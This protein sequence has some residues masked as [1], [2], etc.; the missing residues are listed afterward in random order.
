M[1]G[2]SLLRRLGQSLHHL[3]LSSLVFQAE[4]VVGLQDHRVEV[5]ALGA[6]LL[7]HDLYVG[8]GSL[9]DGFFH[10]LLQTCTGL[11][12]PHRLRRRESERGPVWGAV[13]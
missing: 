7:R 5:G 12:V 10:A 8:F 1:Q 2:Y 13:G 11:V 9:L 4:L 6:R 3:D